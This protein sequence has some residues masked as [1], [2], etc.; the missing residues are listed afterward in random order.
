ME[1]VPYVHFNGRCEEALNFYRDAVGGEITAIMKFS[2]AP[3]KEMIPP[4]AENHV[5]HASM[6]I[7]QGTLLASDGV[8]DPNQQM[9]GFSLSV[10]VATVE[11]GQRV[12]KALSEGGKVT[13]PFEKTFWTTGFGMLVDRFGV[14][15]M[16][17]VN[18]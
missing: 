15:W 8:T 13:M 12:F 11:E 4:G 14:S 3:Q 9:S 6:R 16:V 10:G 18:H 2:E 7:G 1:L 5:M 17:N